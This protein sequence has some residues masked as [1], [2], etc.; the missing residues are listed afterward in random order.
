MTNQ[1]KTLPPFFC[2]KIETPIWGI[3]K[4]TT[5][6]EMAQFVDE[7]SSAMEALAY[8]GWVIIFDISKDTI[9]IS[10]EMSQ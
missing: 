3:R 4:P 2:D 5:P 10:S 7:L 8:L 9:E 6:D 1:P